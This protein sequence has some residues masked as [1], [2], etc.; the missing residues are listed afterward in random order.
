MFFESMDSSWQSLL[1]PSRELLD[2]IEK[3][4][5]ATQNL[6][7]ARN[8]VMRAFELPVA[9][10]RVL[11]LGQDPYPTK[12]MACG[13]AFA[14]APGTKTPQSLKNLM[15]ELESD[16]RG[17]S[18]SADLAKWSRQGVMLLNSALTTEVGISGAHQK[19][20]RKFIEE[21]IIALDQA[22]NGNLVC[23]SLGLDA[24][25]LAALIELGEV[26]YAPH[27]SPLSAHRGFFGSKIY[28]RV[29]QALSDQGQE[30]I[31]WSC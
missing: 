2:Q 27:P 9:K 3:S 11:M 1:D 7:P 13:L 21:V 28:S 20:W 14:N 23:L 29:N 5:E 31:D 12:G 19:L 30:P 8:Q 25:K 15:K 4:L 6:T 17:V 10:V 24:K 26:V 22:R 16:F 18:T